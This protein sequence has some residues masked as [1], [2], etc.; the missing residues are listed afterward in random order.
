MSAHRK[1]VDFPRA[2]TQEYFKGVDERVRGLAARVLIGIGKHYGPEDDVMI[3]RV[4]ESAPGS[5]VLILLRQVLTEEMGYEDVEWFIHDHFL[6]DL[7]VL[8]KNIPLL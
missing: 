1:I 2:S 5:H 6:W 7:I 3:F 8:R 4:P